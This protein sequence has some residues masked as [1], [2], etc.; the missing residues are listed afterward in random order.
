MQNLPP[1][2]RPSTSYSHSIPVKCTLLLILPP[3]YTSTH[4]NLHPP[5]SLP[6]QW[7]FPFLLSG[8]HSLIDLSAHTRWFIYPFFRL[9]THSFI[10]SSTYSLIHPPS[11]TKTFINITSSYTNPHRFIHSLT[12]SHTLPFTFTLTQTHTNISKEDVP[13]WCN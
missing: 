11:E 7:Q 6:A 5:T 1:I 4:S 10:H 12:Q 2:G 8:T 3:T 9:A 13:T